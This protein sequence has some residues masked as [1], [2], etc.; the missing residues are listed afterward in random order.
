MLADLGDQAI[1]LGDGDEDIGRD[2]AE[3]RMG[4]AGQRFLPDDP[5][6]GAIGDRLK[7]EIEFAARRGMVGARPI[8]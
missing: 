1:F 3:G 6:R 7:G 2:G 8:R 4:P 5:A